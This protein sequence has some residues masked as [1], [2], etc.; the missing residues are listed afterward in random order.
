MERQLAS[1]L[2]SL[3]R[4][5]IL[6]NYSVQFGRFLS[7]NL[8]VKSRKYPHFSSLSR[9]NNGQS[10]FGLP[11]SHILAIQFSTPTSGRLAKTCFGSRT[12]SSPARMFFK[13]IIIRRLGNV[14]S[15]IKFRPRSSPFFN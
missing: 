12:S 8:S 2:V 7:F 1:G 4:L 14:R 15:H 10:L 3:F 13:I 9:A 5:A 6:D 11:I